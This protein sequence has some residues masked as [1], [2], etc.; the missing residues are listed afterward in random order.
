MVVTE[1]ESH[2]TI[3]ETT[4]VSSIDLHGDLLFSSESRMCEG[5]SCM[6]W[7]WYD[8]SEVAISY[9]S[10]GVVTTEK[11]TDRRGYCGKSGKPEHE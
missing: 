6:H 9:D 4:T 1:S 11:V 5:C 7:R 3:C 10:A 8:P 2:N